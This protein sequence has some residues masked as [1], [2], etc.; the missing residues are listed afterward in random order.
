M[1][2]PNVS[3]HNLSMWEHGM[4]TTHAAC[5]V[6]SDSITTDLQQLNEQQA[7]L[8]FPVVV[9]LATLMCVGI[10]GNF[11]VIL[12]YKK[13]KM[14][15]RSHIFVCSLAIVDLLGCITAM[16][17]EIYDLLHPY[18]FH[19]IPA[20]KTVRYFSAFTVYIQSFLLLAV[21]YD[22]YSV[23]FSPLKVFNRSRIKLICGIIAISSAILA[24]PTIPLFGITVIP[25]NGTEGHDC[26]VE[27]QYRNSLYLQ[28]YFGWLLCLFFATLSILTGLYGR[29]WCGIK[30]RQ[31]RLNSSEVSVRLNS[32]EIPIRLSSSDSPAR[33]KSKTLMSLSI[34]DD[35]DLSDFHGG[36]IHRYPASKSKKIGKTTLLFLLLSIVFVISSLPGVIVMLLRAGIRHFDANVAPTGEI[37]LKLFSRF[38]FVNN[39]IN[40][41]IYSWI[42]PEFRREIKRCSDTLL[43]CFRTKNI[44]N[45]YNDDVFVSYRKQLH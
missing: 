7:S 35:G 27:E 36:S 41:F 19:S 32:S 1:Y 38:Y 10:I 5:N 24:S 22:R 44:K 29:V 42:H 20:C 25:F 11:F 23:V 34:S 8:L 45:E 6:T 16:P 37:F 17:I 21:A 30:R 26:S 40:P 18:T 33:P 13:G 9:V 39:S 28:I 31:R 2:Q 15:K 43:R 3:G 14:K 12:I 4:N